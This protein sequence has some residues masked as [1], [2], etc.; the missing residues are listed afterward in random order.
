MKEIPQFEPGDLNTTMAWYLTGKVTMQQLCDELNTRLREKAEASR[1]L[2]ERNREE[3]DCR[4][5]SAEC[6]R[7]ITRRPNCF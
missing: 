1:E 6:D 5:W 7:A 4:R 2:D 3:E